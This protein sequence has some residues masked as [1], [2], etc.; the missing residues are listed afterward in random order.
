[1]RR[2][3][4]RRRASRRPRLVPILFLLV[5]SLAIYDFISFAGRAAS[6]PRP[7]GVEAD[8]V[9]ALTGGSGLR[10]AAGVDLVSSGKGARLLVSGVHPDVTMSELADLAGGSMETYDCCVDIGYRAETTIGNADETAQWAAENG[11][12]TLIIVT[13]DYHLP[14]SLLLLQAAMPDVELMP[15]PVRTTIDP[16]RIWREPKSFQ[17]VLTEWAKWRVTT[18]R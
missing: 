5:A 11:Y 14:R 3:R 4:E 8:G 1:M 2:G 15:Y 12:D 7:V 16:S 10:I 17:G 13:S 18:L 6:T 9:V